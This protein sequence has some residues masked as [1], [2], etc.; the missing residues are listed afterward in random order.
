MRNPSHFILFS[1]LLFLFLLPLLTASVT[2]GP[3]TTL[4]TL[5]DV[6]DSVRKFAY[7][8]LAPI[9]IVVVLIGAFNFLT[10][11]GDPT[12]VAKA[13]QILTYGAIGV[14]VV[15]LAAA[16]P[17]ILMNVMGIEKPVAQLPPGTQTCS[18]L[19]GV[20]CPADKICTTGRISGA[21][22][23]VDCCFSAA[24][25]Q[26]ISPP[27]PGWPTDPQAALAKFLSEPDKIDSPILKALAERKKLID[28]LFSP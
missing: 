13:K 5:F 2:I 8:F 9:A 21:S 27:P 19:N 25:C 22:D 6:F 14:A 15:I 11:A 20:C 24:N 7:F 12:K 3:Y 10:S 4:L 16:L 18:Q 26:E 17:S 23:C 28:E 1:V